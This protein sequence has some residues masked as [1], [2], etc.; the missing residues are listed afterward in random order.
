[1]IGQKTLNKLPQISSDAYIAQSARVGGGGY[2]CGVFGIP[3]NHPHSE[4]P[5]PDAWPDL[6]ST[7]VPGWKVPVV[8]SAPQSFSIHGCILPQ[9]SV[10]V[11]DRWVVSSESSCRADSEAFLERT[12]LCKMLASL[13]HPFIDRISPSPKAELLDFNSAD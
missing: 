12:L 8:A 3:G 5:P 2:T 11:T 4:R 7:L 10:C 13:G 1:V 6:R 9:S